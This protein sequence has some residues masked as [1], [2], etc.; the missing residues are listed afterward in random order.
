MV[1]VFGSQFLGMKQFQ[2]VFAVNVA[3]D[4]PLAEEEPF[5]NLPGFG[6]VVALLQ[7]HQLAILAQE[8][9]KGVEE[10]SRNLVPDR[11]GLESCQTGVF[12]AVDFTPEIAGAEDI[13]VLIHDAA[14]VRMLVHD[15]NPDPLLLVTVNIVPLG[16]FGKLSK[17]FV[18]DS[19]VSEVE[20]LECLP[21]LFMVDVDQFE[22]EKLDPGNSQIGNDFSDDPVVVTIADGDGSFQRLADAPEDQSPA[23]P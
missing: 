11:Q 18:G 17:L 9:V 6:D 12:E 10:R 2:H 3:L 13:A 15:V 16:K 20:S 8:F 5:E 7:F 23:A 4:L 14:V 19:L 21:I 1:A 22:K